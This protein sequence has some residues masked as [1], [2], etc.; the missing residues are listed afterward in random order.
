MG[1]QWRVLLDSARSAYFW[2]TFK[3]LLGVVVT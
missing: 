2:F 3:F 1:I